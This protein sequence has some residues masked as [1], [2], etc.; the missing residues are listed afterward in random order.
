MSSASPMALGLYFIDVLACLLFCLT[1]A[2]VNAR[3]GREVTVPVEL[4]R[5]VSDAA[6]GMDLASVEVVLRASPGGVEAFY[7]SE[8]IALDAL[9]ARLAAEPPAALVVRSEQTPLTR[10]IGAAHEAGVHD[11]QLA[12][13]A[14]KEGAK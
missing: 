11:I 1:L 10:V 14:A 9:A 3:F 8:P 4:P 2:L 12:Y 6:T 5:L 7:D 13:D